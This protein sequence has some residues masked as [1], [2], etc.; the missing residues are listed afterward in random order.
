MRIKGIF[1]SKSSNFDSFYC[2]N[3]NK[4]F[5][6]FKE[7]SK[8]RGASNT[9]FTSTILEGASNRGRASHMGGT[10]IM[11]RGLEHILALRLFPFSFL[12]KAHN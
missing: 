4:S 11:G 3:T 7:V 1:T 5:Q 9:S 12:D 2:E 10:S 8:M 6:K